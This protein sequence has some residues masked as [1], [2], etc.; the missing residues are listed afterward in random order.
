M[1]HKLL[2]QLLPSVLV[3]HHPSVSCAEPTATARWPAYGNIESRLIRAS[4]LQCPLG[5]QDTG[6]VGQ[7][8]EDRISVTF[9]YTIQD[10]QQHP[11]DEDV[12]GLFRD[13]P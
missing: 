1:P 9:D 8:H 11:R 10:G 2:Q 7:Q 12:S 3:S 5:G 4:L 6:T 13:R